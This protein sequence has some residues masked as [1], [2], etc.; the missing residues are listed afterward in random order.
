MTEREERARADYV[1]ADEE[2]RK[3]K[4]E[5]GRSG[6]KARERAHRRGGTK[7]GGSV[8]IVNRKEPGG[9][10]G[11]TEKKQRMLKKTVERK[12]ARQ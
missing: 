6:R 10:Q 11:Q 8:G 7:P 9:Q 3:E 1:T 4:A 2:R 12:I 5:Y